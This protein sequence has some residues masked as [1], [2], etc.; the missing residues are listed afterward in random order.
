MR[1]VPTL[2]LLVGCEAWLETDTDVP[3]WQ[4]ETGDT[5]DTDTD[6]DSGTAATGCPN[7]WAEASSVQISVQ[8]FALDGLQRSAVLS[9]RTYKDVSPACVS[10]DGHEV[11]VLLAVDD[12]DV[13]WVRSLGDGP[14]NESLTT[15]SGVEVD[16]FGHAPAT[17]FG[18]GDWITGTWMISQDT[19]SGSWIHAINGQARVDT[20]TVA[21]TVTIAVK[22]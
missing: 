13:A 11:Q 5:A 15:A 19:A 2:L 10:S 17:A 22:P 7:G 4:P 21:L 12:D 14:T 20:A 9:T 8:T 6:T 18:P 1:L 3:E 16:A